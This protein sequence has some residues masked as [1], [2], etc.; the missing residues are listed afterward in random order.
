MPHYDDAL[1]VA[2]ARAQFFAA[3]RFDDGGYDK[4][5]LESKIGPFKLYLANNDTRQKGLKVHDLHHIA[6][7]Y[8]ATILGEAE[9][10]AW[11]L[12]S[13]GAGLYSAVEWYLYLGIVAGLFLNPLAVWRAY[14]RGKGCKNLYAFTFDE[15]ML[16]WTVG[17]LRA[18]LGIVAIR[19]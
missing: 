19:R 3:N 16:T 14:Q 12:G 5:Y 2:E 13:G 8:N 6:T 18:K 11:E 15:A 7:G 10:S 4:A 9:V 1:S 17:E